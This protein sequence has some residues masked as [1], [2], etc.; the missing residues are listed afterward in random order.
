LGKPFLKGTELEKRLKTRCFIFSYIVI[1]GLL[2]AFFPII[3][4]ICNFFSDT[5]SLYFYSSHLQANAAI[6]S[7]FGL[8]IIFKIQSLE[9][10]IET[11]KTCLTSMDHA[12][13]NNVLSFYDMTLSQK[14]S[15][16]DDYP[17]KER[18]RFKYLKKW[19][20]IEL[21]ISQIKRS[22]RN[23]ALLLLLIIAFNSLGI[24]FSNYLH[25]LGYNYEI[26]FMVFGVMIQL[27][28]LYFLVEVIKESIGHSSL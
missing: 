16:I 12:L 24:M 9:S 3:V 27:F 22:S 18:G 8:F 28:A 15:Y 25:I 20:E 1:T 5:S 17:E 4:S 6:L 19:Y 26:R 23:P 11:I 13:A 7:I 14:C 21:L 10:S 2:V